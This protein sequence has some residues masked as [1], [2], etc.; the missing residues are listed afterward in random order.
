M[1]SPP[2]WPAGPDACAECLSV[3][4]LFSFITKITSSSPQ[5]R[6]IAPVLK[7]TVARYFLASVFSWI[8]SIW[9]PDFEATTLSIF[10]ANSR[11]Y[12]CFSTNPR[13]KLLRGIQKTFE[14]SKNNSVNQSISGP[15]LHIMNDFSLYSPFN[16]FRSNCKF[17][18]TQNSLN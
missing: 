14:D 17:L 2:K 11:R 10:F 8:Y 5:P 18:C 13:C 1:E 6:R 9:G 7:G 12:S 16:P 15:A 3:F 4:P